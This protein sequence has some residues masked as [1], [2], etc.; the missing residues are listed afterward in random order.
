MLTSETEL[1]TLQ[2]MSLADGEG[3]CM[4]I[5]PLSIP[6]R[7]STSLLN[8]TSILAGWT[9]VP[10]ALGILLLLLVSVALSVSKKR[11]VLTINIGLGGA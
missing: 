10:V 2:A 11:A 3:S 4:P 8:L 6:E 9:E 7:H 5:L 1:S